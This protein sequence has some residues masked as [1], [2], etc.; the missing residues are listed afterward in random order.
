MFSGELPLFALLA[1]TWT[2][3]KI[4]EH[5]L[6]ISPILGSLAAGVLVGPAALNLVA[7][8]AAYALIGKAGIMLLVLESGFQVD[9]NSVRRLGGYA[10]LAAFAGVLGPV[11][12]ALAIVVGV[13]GLSTLSGLA[14][15]AALAPTSLGFSAKLLDDAG[16]RE[17]PLGA[18]ICTAAVFDDVIGLTML[19]YLK[20]LSTGVVAGSAVV[21][22][23]TA[24][25]TAN[26][27]ADA[28]VGRA[29]PSAWNLATPALGSLGSIIIGAGLSA[30]LPPYLE[31]ASARACKA[32][33]PRHVI[34]TSVF[35]VSTVF[36]LACAALGSSVSLERRR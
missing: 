36:A 25:F 12:L 17:T 19:S 14:V 13:Y 31:A 7:H 3:D 6:G 35:T 28:L 22:N 21:D 4:T 18:I 20:V 1:S 30:L 33:K 26:A 34:L 5:G 24:N 16:L 11:I 9:Q 8:P 15:G 27:T 29:G 2:L 32:F 23:A 10:F